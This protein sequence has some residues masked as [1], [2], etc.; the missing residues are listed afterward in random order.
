MIDDLKPLV[1][2]VTCTFN[3][4][5]SLPELYKSLKKQQKKNFVWMIIDDNSSDQTEKMVRNWVRQN[6]G[7]SIVY[8]KRKEQGGKYKCLNIAFSKISTDL[9][10]IIDSDDTLVQNGSELIENVWRSNRNDTSIGSFIFEHGDTSIEDP[11]LKI[12]NNGEKD[13]RYYY[14]L[15]NHLIGDYADVFITQRVKSFRFKE[16]KN[17]YFMS[18]GVLY[19]WMSQKYKSLFISKVLTIGSYQKDGLSSN[20][21]KVE[22]ESFNGT[23]YETEFYFGTDTPL[24]YRVKKAILYDFIVIEKKLPI[25]K[26]IMK[27]KHACLLALLLPVAFLYKL[28]Y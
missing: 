9:F 5:E 27:N 17:E 11:M 16:F 18:E 13:Y 28:R 21:R 20:L 14:M 19:Y 4:A 24:W 26:K 23:L 7:F 3:R 2:V 8:Y 10:V 25:S 15:K 6:S 22:L 1:T 12:K